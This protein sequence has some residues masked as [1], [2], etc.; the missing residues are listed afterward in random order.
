MST[1]I[2]ETE[3]DSPE[4]PPD[5][6]T[7]GKNGN[8]EPKPRRG[9]VAL[10][11]FAFLLALA[12]L[13]GTGW[14]WWQD[15]VSEGQES[16][17]QLS[18]IAAL[19]SRNKDLS[20]RL[21]RLSGDLNSRDSG[22]EA[23]QI[24]ALQ[25]RMEAD[26]T[27]T[28]QLAESLREQQAL[29]RS[30]Q[31]TVSSLGSRLRA[32]EAAV[33]GLS[34]RELDAAGDL[35]L[36]E[37]AYLLRLAN[38]RL[39]L[40]SD[41]TSADEALALADS[42]LAALDNPMYLGVRQ[43]IAAARQQLS[44]LA[45]PDYLA[46]SGRL[47]SL[48]QQAATLPFPEDDGS[49]GNSGPAAAEGWWEKVKGV[50]SNLVTVRRSTAVENQRIS[51]RDKDYIRQGIWLQ[52]ET[53]RLALMRQDQEAFS[54][55]LGRARSTVE[56][57]FGTDSVRTRAV[58]QGIDELSKLQVKI[59]YPDISAPWSTLRLLRDRP[60]PAAAPPVQTTPDTAS[61]EPVEG[62]G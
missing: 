12:A 33:A 62:N 47:D 54:A 11:F 51:L 55:A 24:D 29:S 49:A 56:T 26:N 27:R 19:D 17:R 15:R 50:F 41:V 60:D 52:F 1:E 46:I 61:Q 36:A 43:D 6:N 2:T 30:L 53:A 4:L 20:D 38:E 22:E 48:Q 58:L 10:A 59:D 44:S 21:D 8:S 5:E 14:Q 35:D 39:R 16:E 9:G 45:I 34:N 25:K 37:V 32:S 42:N 40:F 18:A 31:S 28:G 13:A 7:E 23:A 3:P 57:W